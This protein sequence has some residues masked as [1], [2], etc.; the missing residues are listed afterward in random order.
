MAG[1][2]HL[3]CCVQERTSSVARRH[4]VDT[5]A[6]PA[7]RHVVKRFNEKLQS[8]LALYRERGLVGVTSEAVGRVFERTEF[9]AL[10]RDLRQPVPPVRCVVE[11]QLRR[12]DDVTFSRFKDM[13]A[14]FCRH[15]QYRT[16]WRQRHCYGAFVGERICALMW[17]LFAADNNR[18]VTKW[19]YLLA[20]EARI[21]SIWADPEY[22]G[23]GLMASCIGKFAILLGAAGF[24]YLYAFTWVGNRSSI[25]LHAKLGF[26]EVGRIRRY[27]FAWQSEGNGVYIRQ[28]IPREPIAAVRPGGDFDLPAVIP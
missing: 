10:Q 23:T 27:S 11:F 5:V 25:G 14:P 7:G 6:V 4:S 8:A 20:D 17:P 1:A 2:V 9:V 22:R 26:R 18:L 28:T 19:R 15:Y 3:R 13:P 24:H 12:I 21:S 16:E